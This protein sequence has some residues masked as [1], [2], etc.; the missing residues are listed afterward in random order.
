MNFLFFPDLTYSQLVTMSPFE[1]VLVAFDLPG[2]VLIDVLEYSLT[3]INLQENKTSSSNFLQVAGLKV[4]YDFT[5]PIGQ[6]VVSIKVRCSECIVPVLK[7]LEYEKLYRIV[8]PKFLVDGGD[9]FTMI[10]ENAK[11]LQ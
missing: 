4:V 5:Q 6:R 2:R 10:P 11:N 7:P 3:E 9:G 8:T 1:N